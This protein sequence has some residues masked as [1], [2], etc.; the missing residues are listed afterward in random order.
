MLDG[1]ASMPAFSVL[2]TSEVEDGDGIEE[3]SHETEL[4]IFICFSSAYI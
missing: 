3:D 2:D 4:G 1:E